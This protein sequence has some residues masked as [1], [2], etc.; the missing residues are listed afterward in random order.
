MLAARAG[1]L[2]QR[3]IKIMNESPK[4]PEGTGIRVPM[5]NLKDIAAVKMLA[6]IKI[7]N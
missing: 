6:A 5:K 3:I 2:P 4:Y 7:A 1:K